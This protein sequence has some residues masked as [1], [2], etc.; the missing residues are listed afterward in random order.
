MYD[1]KGEM[2]REMVEVMGRGYVPDYYEQMASGF[3]VIAESAIEGAVKEA[4][5]KEKRRRSARRTKGK[6]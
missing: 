3:I 2:Y 6:R 4:V 1:W 5:T